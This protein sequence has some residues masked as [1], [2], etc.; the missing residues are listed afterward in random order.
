[1]T[2]PLLAAPRRRHPLPAPGRVAPGQALEWLGAGWRAFIANPAVW[3]VQTVILIV[4]LS[5]LGLVPFLGWAA[6]PLAFPVLVGGM[7]AGAHA[8]D[9]GEPLRIDHLFDGLR[10]HA[11]N[12]LMIGLSREAPSLV[13]RLQGSRLWRAP[14]LTGALM[15]DP[16]TS[17]DRF[18][19]TAELGAPAPAA[20]RAPPQPQ[21][22]DA[23]GG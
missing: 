20:Q 16:V 13:Q 10:R 6:A 14:S 21:P 8:L 22:E 2:D 4:I 3:V 18:T 15:P 11:G 17:R 12:L 7:I 5:A 9:R 19:L 23:D 1:M